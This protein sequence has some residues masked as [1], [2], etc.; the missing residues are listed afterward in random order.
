MAQNWTKHI[1]LILNNPNIELETAFEQ[2]MTDMGISIHRG[3]ITTIEQT[4]G[5]VQSV[6]LDT[7]EHIDVE[8][9]LWTPPEKQTLLVKKLVDR[10]N[11]DLN[12]MGHLNTDANQETKIKGL[13]AAGD[14]QGWSGAIEAAM[15][16]SI[17]A[18]MIVHGWYR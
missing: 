16:G 5:K 15:A 3:A 4:G 7:G 12:E 13:Y 2:E 9:L 10:F 14:V 18:S 17:A 1:K 8:T 6:T 11:L